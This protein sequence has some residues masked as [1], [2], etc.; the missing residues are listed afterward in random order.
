[1]AMISVFVGLTTLVHMERTAPSYAGLPHL[2]GSSAIVT[3]RLACGERCI[4]SLIDGKHLVR[5]AGAI[6]V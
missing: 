6:W 5:Q 1:M 2:S 3:G 4:Q